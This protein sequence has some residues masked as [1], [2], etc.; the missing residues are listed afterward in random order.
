M[1]IDEVASYKKSSRAIFLD[2]DGVITANVFYREWGEWEAAM[3][4]EDV[5]LLPN[6]LEALLRLQD[7]DYSLFLIS[8]QGAFAKG[9][10][11]LKSLI[12]TA[13]Y[14]ADLLKNAGVCLTQAY[15]SF[16]HPNG[17]VKD[18]SG[19]SLERKPSPYFLHVAAAAY[20]ID[21]S[22][23]WMIG[24]RDTDIQCGKLAGCKTA[25][26]LDVH[27]KIYSDS[28]IPDV[29]AKSLYDAVPVI[30]K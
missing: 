17:I 8:N 25:R 4:P 16:T 15:Y 6:V 10:V 9:K 30:L 2:R 11:S 19:I 13:N 5:S 18:F 28:I 14:I 1:G 7:A 23:S 27:G 21:L 20:D 26:I 12:T 22:N 29:E 3:F 24:D